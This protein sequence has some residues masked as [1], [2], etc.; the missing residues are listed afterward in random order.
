M[1]DDSCFEAAACFRCPTFPVVVTER[2]EL[3][4]DSYSC[5]SLICLEPKTA[6]NLIGSR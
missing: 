4:G 3:E 5:I 2:P 6:G 1:Q